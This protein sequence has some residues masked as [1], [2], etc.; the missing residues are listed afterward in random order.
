VGDAVGTTLSSPSLSADSQR[1]VLYRS[2]AGANPDIW[3]VDARRGVFSRLTSDTADDVGP[4]WSPDGDRII[5]GSNRKGVHDLYQKSVASGGSEELVLSTPQNKFATD[6]SSD[7]RFVLFSSAG[8]TKSADI[9]ALPLAGHG[10][11]FPVAQTN[12]DEYAGQ[13]SP[14]G[15]WIAY[16]SDDSGRFDVYVQPFPGPGNKWPVSTSG[17]SQARWRRDGQELFYVAQDGR[18]MATPIRFG[19]PA[20]APEIGTPVA[21]FAPPLGGALQR[22]DTRHQYMVA[23]DGQRFLV[24][25]VTEE[26]TSPISVILNW[27]PR[28]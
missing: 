23:A 1:I 24:A 20:Q 12:F 14:D 7:G 26:A 10:K 5:F 11:P 13:F 6:W 25:T 16:Q 15:N 27:K 18:L 9:W 4:V 22:A 19:S 21:L 28:P 3:T 17:G 8:S 2:L